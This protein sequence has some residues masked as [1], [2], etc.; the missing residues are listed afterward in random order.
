MTAFPRGP[1]ASAEGKPGNVVFS[2]IRDS[3][4]IWPGNGICNRSRPD[5]FIGSSGRGQGNPGQ[6][7]R[8]ALEHPANLDWRPA[9]GQRSSGNQPGKDSQGDHG[10]GRVGSRLAG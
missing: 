3:N 5:S 4:G 9:P 1:V 10:A 8:E 2:F 7:A 6:G